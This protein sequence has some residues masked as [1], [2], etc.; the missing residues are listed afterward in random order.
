MREEGYQRALAFSLQEAGLSFE[1]QK[2]NSVF[3][4]PN[5]QNLVGYYIPDFVVE[6]K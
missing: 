4:A 5:E 3:S 2:L 1:P 6:E